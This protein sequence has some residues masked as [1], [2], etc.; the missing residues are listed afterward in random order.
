MQTPTAVVQGKEDTRLYYQCFQRETALLDINQII[1]AIDNP[2]ISS[3]PLAGDPILSIPGAYSKYANCIVNMYASAVIQFQYPAGLGLVSYR[4]NIVR[5]GSSGANNVTVDGVPQTF[6]FT[7]P[8]YQ[9]GL[10]GIPSVLD[11]SRMNCA[12]SIVEST[13]GYNYNGTN[14]TI[15]PGSVHKVLLTFDVVLN[16]TNGTH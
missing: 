15:L 11:F 6:N 10:S 9:Y 2:L 5:I 3:G 7:Q 16:L 13:S 14:Y 4:A 12:I 1:T 8:A